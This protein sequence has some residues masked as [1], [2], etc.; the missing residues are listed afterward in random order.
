[1]HVTNDKVDQGGAIQILMTRWKGGMVVA[2]QTVNEEVR[3]PPREGTDSIE[4]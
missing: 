4:R 2:G 1:M 3:M